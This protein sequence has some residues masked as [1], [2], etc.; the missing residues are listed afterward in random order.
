[1]DLWENEML[2][3]HG[4]YMPAV[5]AEDYDEIGFVYIEHEQFRFLLLYVKHGEDFEILRI[6]Q[7]TSLYVSI[8]L[9]DEVI[10]MLDCTMTCMFINPFL[11][12]TK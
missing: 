1:M 4:W 6:G 3:E 7:N 10:S 2:Q 5:L 12:R 9:F 11:E 8:I